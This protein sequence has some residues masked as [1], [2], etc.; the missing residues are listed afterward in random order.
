ERA[1]GHHRA[2]RGK[3]LWLVSW[4]SAARQGSQRRKK[5]APGFH[6]P[7]WLRHHRQGPPLSDTADQGRILSRIQRWRTHLYPAETGVGGQK[8][9]GHLRRLSPALPGAS[10][11]ARRT[12][13]SSRKVT[14]PSLHSATCM[15]APKRPVA[16]SP[17]S[18]LTQAVK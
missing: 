10:P 16:T 17:I 3:A 4:R 14:G 15:S 5:D 7:R 11:R 2:K 6:Q 9:E 13:T 18:R 12:H 1:D 8:T